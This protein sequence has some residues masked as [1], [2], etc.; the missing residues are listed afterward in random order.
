MEIRHHGRYGYSP[1]TERPDYDWPDGK[2][3]AFF[4]GLNVEHFSFGE[5][6][7]HTTTVP[8]AQPDV[9]NYAWR[10]Y[11]LRVGIWRLFDLFD[12]LG[13]PASHLVNS[14]V[15]DHAPQIMD[16]I[17]QRGDEVMGHGRTNSESQIDLSE[18]EERRLIT[19]A[20][21][22]IVRHEGRQPG[23]WLGP[24]IAESTVTLDLLKE[25][26][27]RY[28]LDWPCDD[29]PIWMETRSGPLLSMPYPLEIN[30]SPAMLSRRHSAEQ[31]TDMAIG[32]FDE[33]LRL[34]QQQP[35]VCGI[36]LHTFVTG[37]PYRL[38]QLRYI[39]T[40]IVEH[41]E[42]D[43]VWFTRPVDIAD[44]IEAL[45]PGTVPGDPRG[46]E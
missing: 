22:T 15:Y 25:A 4:I 16:R 20:T 11:G 37:Q 24:W 43:R 23:G 6:L 17:R 29:Q 44:H 41:A 28:I 19:E 26:G 7:G 12:E 34:S 21:D 3:L 40:H 30:D 39:L 10:D 45:P 46:T 8:G 18:D 32:Q 36:S 42:A 9:R 14:A 2:R 33:M 27:Y 13:L 38:A 31:F 1:I 5:G 35:L